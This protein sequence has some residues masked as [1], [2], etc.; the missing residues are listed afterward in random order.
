MSFEFFVL[1]IICVTLSPVYNILGEKIIILG[2]VFPI[3]YYKK[4]KFDRGLVVSLLPFVVFFVIKLLF[5]INDYNPIS[6]FHSVLTLAFAM[7]EL[8]VLF[9][10]VQSC[11]FSRLYGFTDKFYKIRR[12][13]L[14]SFYSSLIFSIIIMI[15]K[16]R[17]FYRVNWS[18]GGVFVAPQFYLIISITISMALTY[19]AIKNKKRRLLNIVLILIGFAYA[20]FANYTTQIIFYLFGIALVY[21][22]TILDTVTKRI[23]GVVLLSIF[24]IFTYSMLPEFILFVNDI[25]FMDNYTIHMRLNEIYTLLRYGDSGR[26][27]KIRFDL[28]GYSFETFKNNMLF[29]INFSDYNTMSTGIVVGDHCEW[30]DDLAR[31]GIVGF[32]F[33]ALFSIKG[34]DSIFKIFR[35]NKTMVISYDILIFIYGFAN[36]I[37]KIFLVCGLI[38]SSALLACS[39]DIKDDTE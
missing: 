39:L 32:V 28:M 2:L 37:I 21:L 23:I 3:I 4:I 34:I 26:D 10:C 36:P 18:S 38:L 1:W 12:V 27:L 24:V 15:I 35:L 9:I 29:G 17:D 30:I 7:F 14:I 11:D 16:G 25:F 5:V 6:S 22:L 19:E 31:Y 13:I 20:I 8:F 33:F